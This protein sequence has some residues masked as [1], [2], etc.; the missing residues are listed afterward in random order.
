MAAVDCAECGGEMEPG[1]VVDRGDYSVAAQQY[2]V[3][4]EPTMQKFL[5]M[6]A[7]LKV[8]D[9]PRYDVTTLRCS[10]C[11]LLRSYARPE[12]RCN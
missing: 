11:G 10:R 1:F 9:R 2:W 12:D 7:G 3:G 5:G 8:S 4:G 6:T